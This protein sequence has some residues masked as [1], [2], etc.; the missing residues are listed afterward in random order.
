MLAA[1]A[2]TLVRATLLKGRRGVGARLVEATAT[3][4]SNLGQMLIVDGVARR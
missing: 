4:L 3:S 1:E 2:L